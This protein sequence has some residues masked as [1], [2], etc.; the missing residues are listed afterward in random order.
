MSTSVVAYVVRSG[1]HIQEIAHRFGTTP[2]AI[3]AESGNADLLQRRGDLSMLCA[4]DLLNVP[5]PKRKYISLVV[6]ATNRLVAQIPKVDVHLNLTDGEDPI[7]NAA[8]TIEGADAPIEGTTD[9]AGHVSFSVPVTVRTV[10]LVLTDTRQSFD[11]A[12]GGLDPIEETTGVQMRLAHLGLYNGPPDGRLS[13][14]TRSGI[15]AFQAQQKLPITG[16]LD[17]KTLSALKDTHGA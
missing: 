1:D 5:Q 8:Y 3:R 15:K 2:D 12:V 7:T 14:H 4:G 13:D 6:G 16:E 9:A 17:D 10:R 11:I